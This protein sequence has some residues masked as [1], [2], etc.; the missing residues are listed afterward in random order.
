LEINFEAGSALS[1]LNNFGGYFLQMKVKPE[2]TVA[3]LEDDFKSYPE[4]KIKYAAAYARSLIAAD[5]E[6]G[7]Q[8]AR[9]FAGELQEK[10]NKTEE[11][12]M[13]LQSVYTTLKDTEPAE[14]TGKEIEQNYPKGIMAKNKKLAQLF[15]EK[16][17]QKL[18]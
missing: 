5:K 11:E 6:N 3:H 12:L 4:L 17:P 15:Q 14:K 10:T 2:T 9:A 1:T 16:D 18:G 8:K 13:A 7:K